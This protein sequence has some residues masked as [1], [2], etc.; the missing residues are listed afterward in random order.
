MEYTGSKV[1]KMKK[2]IT[3]YF[4]IK[5]SIRFPKKYEVELWIN[6]IYTGNGKYNITIVEVYD[7]VK[8]I[9]KDYEKSY[10]YVLSVMKF[11]D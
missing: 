9:T 3:L 5:K 10:N 11:I 2:R 6:N 1:V 8:S 7:Y 4:K